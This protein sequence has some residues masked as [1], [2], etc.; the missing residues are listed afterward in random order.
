VTRLAIWLKREDY[1]L[2]YFINHKVKCR[3]LDW[4]MAKITHLGGAAFTIS[5]FLF[6]WLFSMNLA[7]EGL[8]ALSSSHLIVQIL[9]KSF[10]RHRPYLIDRKVYVIE[11]ALKDFSFPSGHSTAIFSAA[12]TLSLTVPWSAFLLLPVACIVGISRIYLGLHYPTDVTIGGIIGV[13]FAAGT[14]FIL[15]GWV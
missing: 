3:F 15:S 2:L 12:T 6:L 10:S 5:L 4:T 8:I 14:Q 1:R 7:I 11:N 13:L 9:K